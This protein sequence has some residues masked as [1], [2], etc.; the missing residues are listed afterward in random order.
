MARTDPR[1]RSLYWWDRQTTGL[2]LMLADLTTQEY[3]P[4]VHDGIVVAVTETGGSVIKSRGVTS[5][6]CASK[7]LVFNPHE[8]HSGWMGS[9]EH[10]KHRSFYLQ[11]SAVEAVMQTLGAS[12]F[13]YFS[14][15]VIADRE[16]SAGFL[17]LHRALEDGSDLFRERELLCVTFARLFQRHGRGEIRIESAPR[18]AA[19][20]KAVTAMI[21]DR[22][23][24]DLRL[25]ELGAAVTITPFQLIAL[26]K[27][28]IGLTP[29]AYL[30]QVRLKRAGDLL[31]HG[32]PIAD[33][34]IRT[35]F[36]DQSALNKHFKRCF[37]ITPLQFARASACGTRH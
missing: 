29:H 17:A 1:N 11:Q 26:F 27:R 13:P 3:S 8:P 2:S 19:R 18:D 4:H 34:A 23:A 7:L 16:L 21:E 20:L 36:Y 14:H 37:G 32:M 35:G 22:Y 30:T 12:R 9:S 15:N 10:W 33:V 28:S 31:R 25:E 5:E 24:D 6:V